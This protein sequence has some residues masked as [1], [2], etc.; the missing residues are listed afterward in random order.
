MKSWIMQR[1]TDTLT[2][3]D[4]AL[5][6]IDAPAALGPGEVRLKT[7]FISLDPYLSRAMK[8]WEGEHPGWQQGHV[9]GRTVGEVIESRAD[10]LAVGDTVLAVARWQ[11]ENVVPAASATLIPPEIVPPTLVLGV[12]GASGRSAWVGLELAK[13]KAGETMLVSAASG[14]VGSVAGQLGKRRGLRVI[15][16]AG[17]AEKCAYVESIGFD[18]CLDHRL[19]DLAERLAAAAPDGVDIVFENIGQTSLDAA[20]AVI[21]EKGRISLCG[22][23][24][25]YND[26]VPMQLQH[27][28]ALLYK[29]VTLQGFRTADYLDR[30]AEATAELL[31]GVQA[32]WLQYE[33]QITDGLEHAAEAYLAMLR[34]EGIGKRLIRML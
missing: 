18:A 3:D 10:G 5:V 29:M 32:G 4:F 12:L 20:L 26:E 23:A 30:Y 19:P 33:E 14:P 8:V 22:L 21:N 6:E 24:Q 34:G 7:L 2:T 13:P 16:I 15:G 17:G 25:H 31:S 9:Y 1:R 11:A 27:F 28:K